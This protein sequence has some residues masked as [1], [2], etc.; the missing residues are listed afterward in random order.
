MEGNYTC[1]CAGNLSEPGQI[2]PDSTPPSH[3]GKNGH[4]FL[5]NRFPECSPNYEGYCLNGGL[6]IYFGID[7]LFA[8]HCP[9]GYTGKRCEY[10][11]CGGWDLHHV[12]RGQQRSVSSGAVCV[13]CWLSCCSWGCAELTATGLRSGY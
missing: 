4:N 3:L 8:C 13:W 11:A 7:T 2:C 9:V 10:T 12:G 1:T 6:C 5:K